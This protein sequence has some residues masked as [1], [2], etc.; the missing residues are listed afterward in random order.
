[1]FSP[2]DGLERYSLNR[3]GTSGLSVYGVGEGA[4]YDARV[5]EKDTKG[6]GEEM[7]GIEYFNF[8]KNVF[9]QA[10]LFIHPRFVLLYNQ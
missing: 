5:P 9:I 1:M 4:L 3:H 2:A 10:F 7:F 8:H 6:G